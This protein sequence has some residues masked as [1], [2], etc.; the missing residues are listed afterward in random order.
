MIR[1]AP[2]PYYVLGRK[3]CD[4]RWDRL[5]LHYIDQIRVMFEKLS[6]NQSKDDILTLRVKEIAA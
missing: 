2:I 4:L 6:W 3:L 5:Q 1:R